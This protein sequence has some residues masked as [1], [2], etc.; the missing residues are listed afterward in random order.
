MANP[1]VAPPNYTTAVGKLRAILGDTAYVE[2]VP[3]VVGQGDYAWFSDAVL[4]V[5][6]AQTNGDV[7]AAAV[8]GWNQMGDILA[9]E[10]ASITTDD[11]RVQDLWRRAQFFYDRAKDAIAGQGDDIFVLAN[12]GSSCGCHCHEELADPY[13]PFGPLGCCT[14]R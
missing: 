7:N 2:L 12:L 1:G 13:W 14:C 5:F 10:S 8:Y 3:P 11:L 4:E 6:L 9:T